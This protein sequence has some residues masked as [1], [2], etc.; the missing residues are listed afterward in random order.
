[1]QKVPKFSHKQVIIKL[2]RF[3]EAYYDNA[4]GRYISKHTVP[5]QVSIGGTDSCQGDSGGPLVT[6][7]GVKVGGGM[8]YK[9][10]L[11]GLVSRGG[12]CAMKDEPGIYT[13]LAQTCDYG[14]TYYSLF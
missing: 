8:K 2:T 10:F 4:T 12:G 1:M 13:R 3:A 9:A 14:Y 11:I 6:W 7:Q 5:P